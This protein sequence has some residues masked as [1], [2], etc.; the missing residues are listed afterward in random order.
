MSVFSIGEAARKTGVKVPT[1]RYYED[2]GLLPKPARLDNNRRT[3]DQAAVD[4]L[5]FIKHARGMGFEINDIA[6]LLTLRNNPRQS[7][8]EADQIARARLSD[9]EQRI[10]ELQSLR[11]ELKAMVESCHQEHVESCHIIEGLSERPCAACA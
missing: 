7:C 3:F 4:R 1:I 2:I 10:R 11:K 5:S 8:R 6:T 9:I